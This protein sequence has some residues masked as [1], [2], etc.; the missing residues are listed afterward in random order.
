M[1]VNSIKNPL[2]K[3][4]L[5]T[6]KVNTKINQKK[7]QFGTTNEKYFG[8]LYRL[9]M[10]TTRKNRARKTNENL[11]KMRNLENKKTLTAVKLKFSTGFKSGQGPS[12]ITAADVAAMNVAKKITSIFTVIWV[13]RFKSPLPASWVE[14]N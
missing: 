3:V 4:N 10:Y 8:R 5:F 12:W 1:N 6:D 11:T 9:A 14:I 2:T 7:A 13:A